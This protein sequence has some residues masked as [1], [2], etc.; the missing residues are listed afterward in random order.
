[1]AQVGSQA[2]K[3]PHTSGM[4]KKSLHNICYKVYFCKTY[5]FTYF[6]LQIDFTKYFPVLY[7][8]YHTKF[9]TTGI[10]KPLSQR[11]DF[12]RSLMHQY[13]HSSSFVLLPTKFTLGKLEGLIH[14]ILLSFLLI[15][16]LSH[17]F[18][19]AGLE[20]SQESQAPEV[21][22]QWCFKKLWFENLI[23]LLGSFLIHLKS[24]II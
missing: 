3:L 6:P 20:E 2:Q 4:V 24:C 23:C 13:C 8:L 7:D 5:L 17:Y 18:L 11:Y 16:F 19:Q 1:M 9:T 22:N 10:W 15:F 12:P 14:L 21:T